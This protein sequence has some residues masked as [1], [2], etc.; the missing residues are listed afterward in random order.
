M[1][2]PHDLGGAHGFGPVVAEENEPVFHADWEK[3][4][5]ALVMAMGHAAAWHIDTSRHARERT[6]PA[7]YLASSY[8]QIWL[9]G[10]ERLLV[11]H[12]LVSEEEIA[13][14]KSLTPPA[15]LAAAPADGLVEKLMASSSY[16]RAAPAPARFKAGD[17]V[18][19]RVM[20][21]AGHT[22]LPRYVRGRTGT[23]A[24]IRG[25]HVFPDAH[26]GTDNEDPHW[27]YSVAFAADEVWGPQGR[28]GDEIY[29]DLWEPHLE[30]A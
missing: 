27:L 4:A 1:N 17:P 29:L 15:K 20:N 11:E 30:P 21:P 16:E 8:Y 3:R 22:R 5:F 6:P 26:C 19:A 2:G 10:L 13:A 28:V 18:R 12:G 9:A 23:I 7:E 25:C 14:G 24:A